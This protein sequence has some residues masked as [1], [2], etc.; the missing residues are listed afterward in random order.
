MIFPSKTGVLGCKSNLHQTTDQPHTAGAKA[1]QVTKHN[2]QHKYNNKY[3]INITLIHLR[4]RGDALLHKQENCEF[5]FFTQRMK[6]AR[7]VDLWLTK[8]LERPWSSEKIT[9]GLSPDTIVLAEECFAGLDTN[10]KLNFL[11]SFLAVRR[12][13]MMK[14]K[15][16]VENIL[17]QAKEDT[18][19]WVQIVSEVLMK[20]LIELPASPDTVQFPLLPTHEK[21]IESY[22]KISEIR[23]SPLE[24]IAE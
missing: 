21:F 8:R 3:I 1:T 5:S 19:T 20:K 9:T 6:S 12:P 18:D 13:N 11:I 14:M 16:N 15:D 22:Q 24:R 7:D 10:T 23:K 4:P 17:K 2:K